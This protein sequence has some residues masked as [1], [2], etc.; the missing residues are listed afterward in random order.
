MANQWWKPKMHRKVLSGLCKGMKAHYFIK[1]AVLYFKKKKCISLYAC[2]WLNFPVFFS[3]NIHEVWVRKYSILCLI[4]IPKEC[5]SFGW[6]NAAISHSPKLSFMATMQLKSFFPSLCSSLA[7][8]V[9]ISLVITIQK[10]LYQSARFHVYFR[11]HLGEP[12]KGDISLSLSLS[13]THT[14]THTH[15]HS[16]L[17]WY[18][19]D[20]MLIWHSTQC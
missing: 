18:F 5:H 8:V 9:M 10:V 11:T 2:F 1:K 16:N 12:L 19:T 13:L 4:K 17:A 14:H 3:V 6:A 20:I 15:T 7:L